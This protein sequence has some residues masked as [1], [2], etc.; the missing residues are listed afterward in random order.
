MVPTQNL[1]GAEMTA[2]WLQYQEAKDAFS[3]AIRI[4]DDG[5][6]ETADGFDRAQRAILEAHTVDLTGIAIKLGVF[7]DT[8]G[9]SELVEGFLRDLAA[10]G[11]VLPRRAAD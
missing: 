3:A 2:L 11:V 5:T 8:A 9:G 6:P 10:S 7:N 1:T 4:R